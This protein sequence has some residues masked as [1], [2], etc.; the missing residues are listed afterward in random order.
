MEKLS[1]SVREVEESIKDLSCILDSTVR[2]SYKTIS[3]RRGIIIHPSPGRFCIAF[4]MDGNGTRICFRVWKE[5]IPDA[6]ERYRHIGNRIN[7]FGL[8]YFSGFRFISQAL[9]MKCDNRIVPG[10]QMDWIDGK[11]LDKFLQDD[12]RDLTDVERLTFIRDF[13][14][15]IWELRDAGIAHGDLSCQNIMVT[16]NNDIRLV[17]YDSLYVTSMGKSFYQTTGGADAFQ[18]PDRTKGNLALLASIDDDNFSQLVI[19][20]SL[21][22]AYFDHNIVNHY[23]EL[24]L[25]FLPGDY[26]GSTG[27]E[28]LRSLKNSNG[29]KVAAKYASSYGHI[30][31]LMKALESIQGPVHQVPSLLKFASKEAILSENF[32]SELEGA[33]PNRPKVRMMDF[34]TSCGTKF[35]NNEFLY[36]PTCGV[37]RGSYTA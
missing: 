8:E 12:W 37:K 22:V 29:W 35:N 4:P 9:R 21:W 13:Y 19:A 5:I 2:N 23:D 31:T 28:R 25:L 14:Y 26:N 16:S 10:M 15:M 7:S 34:C 18:H 33:S 20:L 32:Y 11:T 17:D 27:Y 3:G 30:S 24:N 1:Y 6:F 36:C